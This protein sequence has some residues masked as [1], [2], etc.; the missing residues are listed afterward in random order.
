MPAHCSW[1]ALVVNTSSLVFSRT[2]GCCEPPCGTFQTVANARVYI[3]QM[4][5]TQLDKR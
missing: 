4:I 2:F 5:E 1:A 3:Q